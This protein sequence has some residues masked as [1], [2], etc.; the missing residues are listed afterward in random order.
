MLNTEKI[1]SVR[2]KTIQWECNLLTK[3]Y[4]FKCTVT[5]YGVNC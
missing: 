3:L 4:F 2:L 1:H 5:V